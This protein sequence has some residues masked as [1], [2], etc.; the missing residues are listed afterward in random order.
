[1]KIKL[2]YLATAIT[3]GVLSLM[4]INPVGAVEIDPAKPVCDQVG[5]DPS[6][7]PDN[8]TTK[9]ETQVGDIISIV[10]IVAGA[11]AVVFLVLGGLMFAMSGGEAEKVK[12]A[13]AIVLYS[14]VGLGLAIIANI[15]TSIVTNTANNLIK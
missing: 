8:S 1:M 15:I 6:L 10:F 5:V 3:I 2:F 13:K 12:K 7:C 4:S 14:L 11:L 9:L